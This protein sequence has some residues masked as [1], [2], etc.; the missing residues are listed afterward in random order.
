MSIY[1]V[2]ISARLT[3][4]M[5]SL[6]NEGG[7]SNHI[8]TRMVNIVDGNGDLHNVNAVSGDMM[9][10]MLAEHLHRLAMNA[11]APLCAGCRTLNANRIS[12]DDDLMA[13]I[14]SAGDIEAIDILLQRCTMDDML[15]NLVTT[16]AV[17]GSKSGKKA[18]AIADEDEESNTADKKGRSL[19]RKSVVEFGW[20]VG[21]PEKTR[22]DSF[23]HVKF[24]DQRDTEAI[25]DQRSDEAKGRNLGQVP[26]HRPA[27]SGVYALVATI[28]AARIGFNDKTQTYVLEEAERKLR[29]RLLLESLLYTLV[30]PSGA[31]RATQAPHIVDVT[32]VLTVSRNVV[33]APTISPLK[34]GYEIQLASL[35][36]MLNGIRPGALEA[37]TF[38]TLH[39]CAEHVRG[40]LDDTPYLL[41]YTG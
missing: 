27:S 12:A 4:D 22:T 13:A 28:E 6:N 18:K 16:K 9:K 29:F 20:L 2:S 15:G 11:G 30:E 25:K 19:A 39:E 40:L 17:K 34:D 26:F 31:M 1:S 33:P 8:Q 24:S 41:R 35:C 3:L 7:E 23:F 37:H 32:G 21:L 14:S 5:H 38:G 36:E 10:H